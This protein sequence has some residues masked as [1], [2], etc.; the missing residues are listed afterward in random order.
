MLT[1][2][3]KEKIVKK[4]GRSEKDTGSCEVQIALLTARIKQISDHLKSF[5]KDKHSRRGLIK[6]V[7]QRRSYLDYLRKQ[8]AKKYEFV[9]DK[10]EIKKKKNS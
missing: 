1:K 9:I 8:D 4:F 7:A 5:P 3:H 6:L 10:V 2:E